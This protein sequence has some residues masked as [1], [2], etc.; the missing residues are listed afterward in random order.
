MSNLLVSLAP[1][2]NQSLSAAIAIITAS[3][4]LYS[5]VRDIHNR[6]ART[7]SALLFFVLITY[8]GDLGV[9]YSENLEAAV[10]WLRFQWLGIAFTPATY[11]HLSDAILTMTGLPS[12]GRRRWAVRSLYVVAAIFLLLVLQTDLVVRDPLPAP[13]PHFTPGPLFSVFVAY[14]VG[15]LIA[16]LWF[17]IRARNRT[18]TAATR[19]RMTYLLIPYPAPALA[20]FPFLL[21]SGR[22]LASPALFYGVLI[23]VDAVLAV[24]LTFMAYPLAFFGTLLPD[25]LV[26]ARMLQ[27]FLRGPVVAIAV[28]GVI[29]WVPQAGEVLGLPGEEVM[30]FFAVATILFLQWTITLVRPHLERWLIYTGDQAEIRRI[31]ELEARLLTGTDFQQL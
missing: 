18:L 27:F 1:L 24:M 23:I 3:F 5:L 16:S 11:V 9:S 19:R 7:F 10:P 22:T 6:V 12:R 17:V 30:P 8:I 14:F 20:V 15:S 21:I 29:V 31:Q 13:A 2:I 4:F 26:K 28:S 25:R